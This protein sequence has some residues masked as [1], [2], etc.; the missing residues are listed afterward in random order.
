MEYLGAANLF[1]MFAFNSLC[2]VVFTYIYVPETLGKT[3]QEIS[4]FFTSKHDE[5]A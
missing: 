3:F 4:E 5:L 1:Y 2:G